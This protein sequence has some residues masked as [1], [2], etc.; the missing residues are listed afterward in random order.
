MSCFCCGSSSQIKA[1][2][3][4]QSQLDNN[5]PNTPGANNDSGSLIT[6]GFTLQVLTDATDNF[7]P[8]CLVDVGSF[9]KVYRG[10]LRETG[11]IVAV[12]HLDM[13]GSRGHREFLV[14]V[15]ML[16]I[17][18]HPN[19]INFI[20]YCAQGN[21]RILVHEYL[22]LGSLDQHLH[23]RSSKQNPP[24][25]W[26][27]R[28]KIA[29]G[30]ASALEYMHSKAIPPVIYRNLKPS[31]I[32]LDNDFNAK[33]YDFGL[34]KL[35]P[36]GDKEHVSASIM[37]TFGYIAPEY[38]KTGLLTL[39]ADVYSF[40]VVLLEL[41]TGRRAVDIT[42]PSKEQNLV[43]WANRIMKKPKKFPELADPLLQGNFPAQGFNQTMAVIAMCLEEKQTARPMMSDVVAAIKHISSEKLDD[44][45]NSPPL[46]A[47]VESNDLVKGADHGI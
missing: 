22:P 35:G 41:V 42:R 13:N 8:E 11:E 34:S 44:N 47:G 25:N 30:T 4:S 46:E 24:L 32:L 6:K 10:N 15:M 16:S 38:E 20:G 31:N 21:E 19:L 1:L 33:L 39:K 12:E 2:R 45:V 36:T 27:T 40:G 23:D 17:L 18:H 37:G 7:S 14:Q 26:Y 29:L 5:D 9:G 3:S 28:M 43:S